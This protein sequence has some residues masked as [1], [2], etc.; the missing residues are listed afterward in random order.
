[1]CRAVTL[2][3]ESTAHTLHV[4]QNQYSTGMTWKRL[5]SPQFQ[6]LSVECGVI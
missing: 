1:M 6:F 3:P 2:L 4:T 5:L